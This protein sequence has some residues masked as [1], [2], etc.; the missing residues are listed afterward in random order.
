M[1]GGWPS[2]SQCVAHQDDGDAEESRDD[3]DGDVVMVMKIRQGMCPNV[4][5]P[6]HKSIG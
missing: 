1:V 2:C 5:I 4:M 6:K 3:G